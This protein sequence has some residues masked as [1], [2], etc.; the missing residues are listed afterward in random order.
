MNKTSNSDLS[1]LKKG[2]T[3]FNKVIEVKYSTTDWRCS[4][5]ASMERTEK[6][7]NYTSQHTIQKALKEAIK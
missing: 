6:Y 2:L 1:H 7:L 4:S 5:L 3:P